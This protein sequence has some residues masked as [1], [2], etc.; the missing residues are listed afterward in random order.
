MKTVK[1]IKSEALQILNSNGA[2]VSL[3]DFTVKQARQLIRE[4]EF[5]QNKK[6]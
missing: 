3:K 4:Y 2:E 6:G 1:Q 5:S